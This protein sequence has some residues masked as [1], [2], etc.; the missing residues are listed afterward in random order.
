MDRGRAL[1]EYDTPKGNKVRTRAYRAPVWDT[2]NI[3]DGPRL[4]LDVALV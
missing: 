4:I 2:S 1:K 3:D